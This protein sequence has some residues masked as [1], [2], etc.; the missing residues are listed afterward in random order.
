MVDIACGSSSGGLIALAKFHLHWPVDRCS[1]TF[2]SFAVRCFQRSK[3]VLGLIKSAIKYAV[4]DAIYDEAVIEDLVQ[5]TYGSTTAFF[6]NTPNTVPGTRVAVTAMTHGSQRIIFTNYNGS[7]S[8]LKDR[9]S[10]GL[11]PRFQD[12]GYIAIRP[13][14]LH[15]EPLLWQVARAT[16]AAPIFFKPVRMAAG[17]FWDGALGFPNPTELA[18]WEASRL[19]PGAV[20]DVA[21]SLGTGEEPKHPRSTN[22]RNR[23]LDAFNLLLDG[24]LEFLNMKMRSRPEQGLLRLNSRLSQ[25]IR[26]D[27][28]ESIE[29]QKHFV[30]INPSAPQDIVDAAT[31]LLL[32]NFYFILDRPIRYDLGVYYCE[33]SI[34]CRGDSYQV[35]DTLTELYGSQIEFV[36]EAEVLSRCELG[37]DIC[38]VC[39]RYR[40]N[41]SFTVRHPSD[42]ITVSIRL[43]DRVTRKISGFPRSLSWFQQQQGF[44]THFG[45]SSHDT[46][47]QIRCLGCTPHG[48][49]RPHK[50]RGDGAL[51]RYSKRIRR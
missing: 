18:T 37:Q 39:H 22:S 23:L 15:K 6:S 7:A 50:R 14:E 24:Q 26:L 29:V 44:N 33:G 2:E 3:S 19:W 31:A 42:P 30:R 41:V 36:M 9:A 34:R 17:E 5:E 48:E 8:I 20:V 11:D 32:S 12:T 43:A 27:D 47:G 16:S 1:K 46:P 38:S 21:I 49:L 13:K 4:T 51:D 10:C 40:K 35:A 25:P 28:A 45:T